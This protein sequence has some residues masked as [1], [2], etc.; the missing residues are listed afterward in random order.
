MLQLQSL[1]V[2][3]RIDAYFRK[4]SKRVEGSFS[5]VPTPSDINMAGLDDRLNTCRYLGLTCLHNFIK[6][7]EMINPAT[8]KLDKKITKWSFA[9]HLMFGEKT[10]N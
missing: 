4:D 10:G 9:A 5:I 2:V 3:G 1:G 7:E 6:F 8:G